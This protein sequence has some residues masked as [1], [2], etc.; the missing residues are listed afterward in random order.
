[1][2]LRVTRQCLERDAGMNEVKMDET[3]VESWAKPV[4]DLNE[5]IRVLHVDD[6]IGFL[7]IA[8]QHLEREASVMVDTAVSVEKAFRKLDEERYDV[9]VSD[10][11]MPAKDGLEFLRELREK[12]DTTPFI[13]LTGKVAEQTAINALN[14]G[15]NRYVNK[16]GETE[17]VFKELTHNV[18]ELAKTGKAERRVHSVRESES[19][20][21]LLVEQS[22]QGITV[23]IGPEPQGVFVN[24][25]MNRIFGYTREEFY[26][27]SPRQIAETIHPED[28]DK[29]FKYFRDRLEGKEAP[30]QYEVRGVRKNGDIIWL[31]VSSRQIKY[32][33]QK[34]VQA[35]FS[36]ITERKKTEQELRRF[37]SAV[38]ASLDGI[39]TG[40][41]DGNIAHA[42]EAALRMYGCDDK[43]DL[44]DKN[45]QNLLVET[46]QARALKNALEIIQTGQGKTA[47]YTALTKSGVEVPIE[48]TTQL[49]VDEKGHPAGF[50]D[51]IRD[52]TERKKAEQT[53]KDSEARFRSLI[54]QSHQGILVAQGPSPH[55]AFVNKSLTDMLGYTAQDFE[56]PETFIKMVPAEDRN[57]FFQFF[58]DRIAGKDVPVNYECRAVR[59]DGSIAW[60][61]VSSGLVMYN[62]QPSIQLVLT[63]IT[64]RKEAEEQRARI[65]RRIQESQ[66]KFEG[67]FV[68]NPE[69]AVY[70]G[71][72]FRIQDINPQFTAL[73][74]YSFKEIQGKRLVDVIVPNDMMEEAQAL[75]DQAARG[76]ASHDSLRKRKD[77]SLVSVS[78]SAAPVT[79]E[80]KLLGYVG[81]YKDISELRGTE[82][83]MKE[84]MQKTV[85]MN[86]KLRVIGSLTRH[87][88]RNKLS[89]IIGNIYLNKKKLKDHPEMLSSLQ[90]MESACN[91]IVRLFDFARD[92]ENLGVEELAH[93]DV[94]D[95][96]Q[97]ATSLF[98][99]LNGVKIENQCHGL[100]VLADSLLRQ[101]FYNLI[102]NSL[103]YGLKTKHIRIYYEKSE[104]NL[105]LTY[106]DDGV[107]IF[108]EAKSR[109]FDEGYTTGKGSGYGLYLIKKMMEVYGW[110]IQETG[111]PSKGARFIIEIPKTNQKGNNNYRIVTH[112]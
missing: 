112:D 72:D 37:S 33:G 17:N 9:I 57:R 79:F 25:A 75:D 71:P 36:D 40:D 27:F 28:R 58:K 105:R 38:K 78:I 87:D 93:V 73:F 97:K 60:L 19:K 16:M 84:M 47:E 23:A 88:V 45:V 48:V 11:E 70:V 104:D 34:A 10:F 21:R 76:Y 106:E 5:K 13:M 83:A 59:K 98:S 1:M 96:V 6:D 80:G 100:T 102:D 51:I 50:V 3:V 8:K 20:Y 53:L 67:L 29:F 12:G 54:E 77:E 26:S 31:E 107:G 95:V 110:T 103:K 85:M 22:L 62:D 43:R 46:D 86:E 56:S 101:L 49:L 81:M 24:E 32:D 66:R 4:F 14:L 18:T 108:Q 15:A 109:I 30:L 94:G 89:V 65:E 39:I 69:A 82:A 7:E 99:D 41:L 2:L 61:N 111:E 52:L 44:I 90:E 55:A 74:G 68:G 35:I 92:Y 63:D 42:N 64:E 91:T